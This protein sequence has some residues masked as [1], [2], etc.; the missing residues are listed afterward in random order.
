MDQT[1][2][3]AHARVSRMLHD[4][5]LQLPPRASVMRLPDSTLTRLAQSKRFS[6]K[7]VRNQH[8]TWS[9]PV[10]PSRRRVKQSDINHVASALHVPTRSWAIRDMLTSAV[11]MDEV[12][13]Q[14]FVQTLE[15]KYPALDLSRRR[16]S[17]G[18]D[19]SEQSDRGASSTLPSVDSE[20]HVHAIR[21]QL[22]GDRQERN[23]SMLSRSK[24][25]LGLSRK[26]LAT[27]RSMQSLSRQ[28][29]ERRKLVKPYI[30]AV[31]E[32]LAKTQGRLMEWRKQQI[33]DKNT[34]EN[35]S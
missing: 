11:Q 26:N 12:H 29:H 17:M 2:N 15:A 4:A 10:L 28:R 14:Q 34:S 22:H 16:Q 9:V 33:L 6:P 3:D 30:T 7:R 21:R 20:Q 31:D 18:S 13:T 25:G 1:S 27:S 24:S 32:R 35:A 23:S 19:D 5:Q 8:M